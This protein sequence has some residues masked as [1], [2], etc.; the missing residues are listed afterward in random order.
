VISA[1]QSNRAGERSRNVLLI[2]LTLFYTSSFI[3][4]AIINILA[5]PIKRDLGLT[6]TEL[7]ILGGIAFA[8]LY[9]VLGIP[10]ARVAER[11]NRLVIITIALTIWSLMTMLCAAAANFW[12]LVAARAGVGIGE[13]ACTPCA[14]SMIGDSF[15]PER[16]ATALSIYSLGIPIGT[17]VGILAGAWV[18]EA[19]SWRAAFVAVGAPGLV[20]A[21]V[22]A[23]VLKE[24]AR[25]RFDPPVD[26]QPPS[27]IAVLRHLWTRRAFRNLLAGVTLSTMVAAGQGA[28]SAPFLLRGNFGVDLSGVAILAMFTGS[29]AFV[30]TLIGGP[31]ADWLSRRDYRLMLGVPAIAYLITAPVLALAYASS[32]LAVLISLVTVGQIAATVYLGPTFGAL[33]NMVEPRM[34]ATAVASVFM[35]VSLLGLGLGPVLIGAISDYAARITPVPGCDAAS[36]DVC[37]DATFAG[38]RIAMIAA[39]FFYLLPAIYYYRAALTLKEGLIQSN[40]AASQAPAHGRAS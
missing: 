3:D 29:A 2:S 7:G 12:H 5:E 31:L 1:V 36:T 24:P 34:R 22:A 14:H 13:A 39:S 10:I 23:L 15:P 40:P 37:A 28:F 27:F 32:N 35:V 17:L 21:L 4:R 9:A 30:G 18:A 33:H 6:D 26:D 8:A 38:L 25:G 20:L 19:Y 11:K 16:R